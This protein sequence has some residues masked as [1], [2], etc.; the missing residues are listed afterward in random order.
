MEKC[1]VSLI[2]ARVVW[3]PFL[4]FSAFFVI[5][6][7]TLL[8]TLNVAL[9]V[10]PNVLNFL[11]L[12]N[13]KF[14]NLKLFL[15]LILWIPKNRPNSQIFLPIFEYIW[16]SLIR[17]C[18]QSLTLHSLS[19]E[20]GSFFWSSMPKQLLQCLYGAFNISTRPLF[21]FFFRY[22]NGILLTANVCIWS[23]VEH[24]KAV[25]FCIAI[26]LGA[27]RIF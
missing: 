6:S 4:I 11:L 5:F 1:V 14:A 17:A 19:E 9:N 13:V 7:Q 20:G 21:R 3:S 10:K 23:W 8:I 16:T 2:W 18:C 25:L 24:S 15:C 27:M 12:L 26:L 22:M